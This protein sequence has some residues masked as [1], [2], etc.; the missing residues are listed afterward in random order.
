MAR[1]DPAV[2]LVGSIFLGL[3]GSAAFVY[4]QRAKRWIPRVAG[5]VLCI[6]PHFVSSV[7]LML[8]VGAAICVAMVWG[9]RRLE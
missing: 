1:G 4:G 8:L 9:T 2:G 6:F 5:V 7:L 3:I